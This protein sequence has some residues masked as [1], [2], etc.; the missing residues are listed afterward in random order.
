MAPSLRRGC[1]VP[2]LE[3]GDVVRDL[4][5]LVSSETPRPAG[6]YSGDRGLTGKAT[7]GFESKYKKGQSTPDGNTE[8][9]PGSVVALTIGRTS[10]QTTDTTTTP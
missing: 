8:A 7:F 10:A 6:A 4:V 3:T 2:A 5:L 9:K 1:T